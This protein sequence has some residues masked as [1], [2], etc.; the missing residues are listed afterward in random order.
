MATT[1]LN[2]LINPERLGAF[3]DAKLTD[4]I[5]LA[6][7]ARIGRDL[8]GQPGNTLTIPTYQYI[9]D[10]TDLAEGESDKPVLLQASST[11][12]TVKKAAKAVELTDEAILSGYGDP[13]N[14]VATQLL[15]SI[16]NKV[17]NDCF[18]A[19]R[20]IDGQMVHAHTGEVTS[21]V[22]A[23]AVLKFGEDIE[24]SMYIFMNPAHYAAIGK[25]PDYVHI[26]NG[27][28]KVNGHVGMIY[29]V[30]V[31]ISNKVSK[32][33]MFIVKEGAVGIELK[34]DTNVEQDRDI[35]T[36][37]NVYAVDKHFVAYLRDA[38]KAIKITIAETE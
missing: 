2:N 8:Q 6:P 4:L 16:A 22:V 32:T 19:L 23:D 29:G 31:V 35:L 20:G 11:Q 34:R 13:V 14:E 7:L 38:S 36:K 15:H 12:V 27:Q 28:V 3:I 30:N 9:G 1:K 24:E 25:S 17:D 10:A 21:D 33:E 5:K 26:S 37:T 18:A